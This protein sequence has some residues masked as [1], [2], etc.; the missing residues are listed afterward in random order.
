MRIFPLLVA[1]ALLACGRTSPVS[2]G[3][4]TLTL[5][6]LELELGEGLPGVTREASFTL[7]NVGRVSVELI[8]VRLAENVTGNL[9][10]VGTVP[11]TLAPGK[12]AA[13]RVRF[14][15]SLPPGRARARVLVSSNA[16][17]LEAL[18]LATTLDPCTPA[19]CGPSMNPCLGDGVCRA[20]ECIRTVLTGKACDDTDACTQGD[21]CSATG[22]CA[23][24]ALVCNSPP[25]SRCIDPSTL[26][27]FQPGTCSPANG[28]CVY[29]PTTRRCDFGC[30]NDKCFDPCEGVT[31]A[32]PPSQCHQ[33]VGT[34]VVQGMTATCRYVLE[35]DKPCDDGNSCTVTD[36]CNAQGAC[37]GQPLACNTPPAGRCIDM[38]NAEVW[39]SPGMCQAGA[40]VY[41]R[42]NDFCSIG[43]LRGQCMA[44][45]DVTLAAG[46]GVD[47]LQEGT[48]A[49][50]RF[51]EP[52]SLVTDSSGTVFVNDTGNGRVRQI[53]N[54]V[55]STVP[56]A[57]GLVG[58]HD[59]ALDGSGGLLVAASGRIHRV[60]NGQLLTLAGTGVGGAAV[61]GPAPMATFG[62]EV[63][64]IGS[65]GG[66]VFVADASNHRIRRIRNGLVT[67]YAGTGMLG[68]NEGANATATF[69]HPHDL[70]LLANGDLVIAE[71]ETHRVRRVT[72]TTTST[73]A[74]TGLIGSIN[75]MPSASRFNTPLDVGVDPE[76]AFYVA[77]TGNSCIRRVTPTRVTTFAGVCGFSGYVEGP[78][79]TARFRDPAGITVSANGVFYVSDTQNSRIR[80]IDC[81]P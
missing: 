29:V 59:V 39:Q 20:G 34:C 3:D 62:S 78:A 68:S 12:S 21:A 38:D 8:R 23:G 16:K 67:T 37:N 28:T 10:L 75:G 1:V 33:N 61:D 19:N 17:P 35:N 64:V 46:S 65:S 76:G 45:C 41:T 80:R 60:L 56:G 48:A 74:G 11:A 24:T 27:T 70:V 57:T 4:P 6:P 71:G 42:R 58:P 66:D 49:Q 54:G 7:S 18:A 40:C 36:R 50:A 31:C 13:I 26:G 72:A 5:A 2:Y 47:G 51:S 81:T 52:Y 25:A 77:D 53:S 14:T 9:D 79:T 32:S 30:I 73:V 55:V 63:S 69:G 22:T 44:R 15:A 43:C